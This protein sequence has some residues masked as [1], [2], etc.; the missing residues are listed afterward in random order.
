[1]GRQQNLLWDQSTQGEEIVQLQLTQF[2]RSAKTWTKHSH[3]ETWT[4]THGNSCGKFHRFRLELHRPWGS[5]D[6]SI[7]LRVFT[8]LKTQCVCLQNLQYQH[9]KHPATHEINS[10]L[11]QRF[12]RSGIIL[13]QSQNLICVL[14]EHH[15][16]VCHSSSPWVLV[17]VSRRIARW[18]VL[19]LGCYRFVS[20]QYFG[21]VSNHW[22][23]N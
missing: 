5:K 10:H 14:D 7:F 11:T 20:W 4:I 1:M 16:V 8:Q 3:A 19:W 9:V 23:T 18:I 6:R 21:S 15:Q 13:G 22:K 17:P 12:V 2:R